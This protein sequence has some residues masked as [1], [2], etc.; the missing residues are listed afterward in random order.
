MSALKHVTSVLTPRIGRN[1]EPSVRAQ[2]F[3]S[4]SVPSANAIQCT[5]AAAVE[6]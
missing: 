5:A 6:S 3:C 4:S 2:V 1:L